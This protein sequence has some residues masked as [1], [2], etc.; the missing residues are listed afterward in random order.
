M[1]PLNEQTAVYKMCYKSVV[2]IFTFNSLMETKNVSTGFIT[3]IVDN[4]ILVCT[5]A[6]AL[7]L[8]SSNTDSLFYDSFSCDITGAYQHGV[9]T[10]NEKP[11]TVSMKILGV[12]MSADFAI[13]YSMKQ[14]SRGYTINGNSYKLTASST[15]FYRERF[16]QLYNI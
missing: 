5:S 7:L 2:P 14:T 8:D 6:H 16:D 1:E 11:I 9:N 15:D 13:L 3:D 10:P 4:R 12:D